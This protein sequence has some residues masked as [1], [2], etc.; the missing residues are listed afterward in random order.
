MAGLK[1]RGYRFQTEIVGASLITVFLAPSNM[2][3]PLA[4]KTTF[5]S[6]MK[7]ASLTSAKPSATNNSNNDNLR[8]TA[9]PKTNGAA[10][11]LPPRTTFKQPH[12]SRITSNV[13]QSLASTISR[14]TPPGPKLSAQTESTARSN[15]LGSLMAPTAATIQRA[16]IPTFSRSSSRISTTSSTANH[17]VPNNNGVSLIS[18][19][20]N[21]TIASRQNSL[22]SSNSVHAATVRKPPTISTKSTYIPDT[23]SI[24]K[25]LA[26]FQNP[27]ECQRQFQILNSE[28]RQLT[29]IVDNKDRQITQLQE[30]LDDCLKQGVGYATVVQYFAKKLK[31]DSHGLDLE[32]ECKLLKG[33]VERLLINESEYNARLAAA[34]EEYKNQAQL[35]HDLKE[36][37]QQEL[38]HTK[39]EH[40]KELSRLHEAQ[41]SELNDLTGQH[42]KIR[43]EFEERVT[44]LETE[45]DTRT[46]ELTELRKEHESLNESYNKLEESL[47][48]DKDA[49]VKYV[50]DKANQLQKEV[51]SL[52]S[53]IEMRTERMH[54]LEKDSILLGEAQQELVTV[55][56]SNKALK[57][58]LESMEAALKNKREKYE[59]LFA[60]RETLSQE[61]KRE[62]KERRRMTMR[63]EQ[64]EYALN[65]SF[66]TDVNNVTPPDADVLE[67]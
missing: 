63:S 19:K 55:K 33:E 36:N 61:L 65:E 44:Y 6:R 58:Q 21:S 53:V 24:R 14:I 64:L 22:A 30:R 51:E 11:R 41:T 32:S 57:Q 50:Q 25:G 16:A 18:T 26:K 4:N 34:V 17:N 29:E 27:I 67:T 40:L 12:P 9:E 47:T 56:D 54:V 3:T 49:R 15:R 42:S 59:T 45:L 52:N 46:K 28:K 5:S 10:S 60:E 35:E 39:E 48:K 1:L 66:A 13:K 23:N 38:E 62:R 7:M 8:S 37:I 2:S 31:I 20:S 43:Q